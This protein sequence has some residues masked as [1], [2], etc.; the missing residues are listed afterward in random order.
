MDTNLIFWL[1]LFIVGAGAIWSLLED[2]K[3]KSSQKRRHNRQRVR[4]TKA[5]QNDI[6]IIEKP[7]YI[8]EFQDK[9]MA[10]KK[11]ATGEQVVKVK[12]LAELDPAQYHY[13]HNLIIPCYRNKNASTQ[14]DSVIVSRFGIFVIEAKYYDGWIF[15]KEQDDQW[16]QTFPN[17]FKNKYANPIKQNKKHIK[18]LTH[19][20]RLPENRF[21]SVIVFTHRN[22]QIKTDLPK[23][24]LHIC[25][26]IKYIQS[27]EQNL[28]S[29]EQIQKMCTILANPEF[30]AN[31]ER[32]KQH[33][34]Y[35]NQLLQNE[36]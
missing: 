29:D 36:H 10:Q 23:N 20:F 11:G 33:I 24:V 26:F 35:V 3:S 14:I 13:F 5:Q 2:N 32:S 15:G 27:F 22:S 1:S 25:N 9:T 6:A 16:T 4:T 30:Q 8:P 18:E 31:D 19:L 7:I 12:A 28:F 34:N 21:H 17:G